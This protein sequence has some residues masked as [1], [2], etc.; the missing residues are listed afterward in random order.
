MK[1]VLDTNA[2]MVPVQLGVDIF[3]DLATLNF[4]EFIVPS[5]VV[6]E[7]ELIA[8]SGRG[9]DQNA[10]R[11]AVSLLDRCKI[12]ETAGN[13]DDAILA[14]A[15]RMGAAVFTNDAELKARLLDTGVSVVYV[16]QRS[17]L[18]KVP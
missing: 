10:A 9:A 17:Y 11:V 15:T 14:L 12:V 6:R 13:V 16:R 1:I 8:S 4:H 18:V 5:G 3:S 2:L 7:L